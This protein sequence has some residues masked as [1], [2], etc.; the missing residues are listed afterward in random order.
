L[1]TPTQIGVQKYLNTAGIPQLFIESGCACWNDSAYPDSFGW[2]PN[3]IVEG[4]ILGKYV[5]SHY[6]GEKVGY[7]YQ[8]DEFGFD[9]VKGLDQ[10]IPKSSVV[11]RQTYVG[12]SAGLAAGLGNQISALKAAGA[13]VVVLYTIPAATALALLAAAGSSYSPQ[14]VVS[15]V[16]A[17]PPTLSGL[18]SSF[19]KGK[20]GPALL[21]GM[22][23]NAYLP[24][25]S[26]SSNPWVQLSKS[27]LA[28]YDPG[29]HWDGNSEFGAAL[30]YSTVE[31]LEAAG[32]NLTRQGLVKTLE[33]KGSS[34][35]ASGLVPFAFSAS[36]HYGFSG[37]EIVKI[38]NG[39]I[40]A[41]SPVYVATNSG[42]ITTYT[43]GELPIPS[44]FKGA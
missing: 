40:S 22:I 28:K 37:S 31:L 27:I 41:V 12:T 30:G 18:L 34:F 23:S 39:A 9:G 16:G 1:G 32:K 5:A 7:L 29:F 14:W 35:A 42:P 36:D 24:A 3:Y 15:S 17:D 43:G 25:E 2:Q 11:G 10:Q 4:K 33:S 38:D 6:K 20:A 44:I 19:S 21:N 8:D 26:D 13:K